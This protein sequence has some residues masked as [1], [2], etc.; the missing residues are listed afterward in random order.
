[1][2]PISL[3]LNLLLAGLL[4]VTLMY[5]YRLSRQLKALKDSHESF[6]RAVG[7]LDRAALRAE[8]G[9]NELRSSTDEAIELLM[10]RI[11]RGRE[12]AK[13]LEVLTAR[14]EA[15]ADKA[16]AARPAAPVRSIFDRPRASASQGAAREIPGLRETTDAEAEAAAEALVLRLSEREALTREPPPRVRESAAVTRARG[17]ELEST[18]ARLDRRFDTLF[19]RPAAKPEPRAEMRQE[20]RFDPREELRAAARPEP[21]TTPRSRAT[22]DDDLFDPPVRAGRLRAFDGGRS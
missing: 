5:G 20:M 6:A 9:L 4:V 16:Q 18:E 19:R 2:S 7:D 21:R 14:A 13:Q 10:G 22:I 11:D 1:M 17:E 3:S 15:A 12:L 8:S